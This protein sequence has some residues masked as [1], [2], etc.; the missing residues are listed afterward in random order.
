MKQ[1]ENKT[2]IEMQFQS[3]DGIH[4]NVA[5]YSKVHLELVVI[6]KACGQFSD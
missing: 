6:P 1:N 5:L 4:S 3:F 2:I